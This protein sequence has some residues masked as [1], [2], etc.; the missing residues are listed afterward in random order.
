MVETCNGTD[1]I[2]DGTVDEDSALGAVIWYADTDGD[3]FGDALNT[4]PGCDAPTGYV[5]DSSDCN[6]GDVGVFP[7]AIEHCDNMDEDCDGTA[8]N[9]VV[10]PLVWYADTDADGYGDGA[11][12]TLA[13][14]LPIGYAEYAGDCDDGDDDLHP[15]G[16]ESDC[17]AAC[18]ARNVAAAVAGETDMR[19]EYDGV[20]CDATSQRSGVGL[21]Q[22]CTDPVTTLDHLVSVR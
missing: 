21:R 5:S 14:D 8:D 6:D 15:D 10:G 9:D 3:G 22:S 19:P 18:R 11:I 20:R 13:C 2:Y 16:I 4:S 7:G 17:L 12:T 1:D